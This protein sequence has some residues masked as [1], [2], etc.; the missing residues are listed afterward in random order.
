MKHAADARY[1]KT[2][3]GR[4]AR[5][6]ANAR[7]NQSEKYKKCR[8]KYRYKTTPQEILQMRLRQKNRCAICDQKFIDTPST[9]HNHET[10]AVRGL[11][12]NLC[13]WGLGH[14]R[15]NPKFLASAINYLHLYE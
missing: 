7:Y 12:C 11:L 15:D 9:D 8:L 6:K 10:G 2:P 1:Q 5:R 4:I 14:F 13:N 3:N